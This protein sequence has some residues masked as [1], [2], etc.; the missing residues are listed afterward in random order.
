VNVPGRSSLDLRDLSDDD[1][2]ALLRE[3]FAFPANADIAPGV[4][5]RL[6]AT[7]SPR[8]WPWTWPRLSRGLALALLGLIV[9]VAVAAA[10]ILGVPGIRIVTV[11]ELERPTP[12][13][14][15]PATDV[16]RVSP[17][18]GL[19]VAMSLEDVRA[20]VEMPVVPPADPALGPPDA[21]YLDRSVAGGMVSMVWTARPN[22]TAAEDTGVGLLVS[23][24]DGAVNPDGFVKL[25]DQG[26]RVEPVSIAGERGWWLHGAT[27][28][29]LRR[30]GTGDESRP[31]VPTRLAG[32]TLLWERQGLTYRLEG[33]VGLERAIEIAMS[34]GG[35]GS[36]AGGVV[37]S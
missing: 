37:P 3:A 19:G 25:R 34:I 32:D 12:A 18:L 30:A 35:N 21:F 31:V 16:S 5:G 36:D 4:L 11:D 23:V 9:A 15:A 14:S 13:V 6:D 26:V 7:G 2:G 27:H 24:F 22:L 33:S 28:L 10:A 20:R 29:F 8:R 17:A 1:L